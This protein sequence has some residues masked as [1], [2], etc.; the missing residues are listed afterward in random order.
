[1]ITLLEDTSPKYKRAPWISLIGLLTVARL[2]GA[3]PDDAGTDRGPDTTLRLVRDAGGFRGL[4][5][6]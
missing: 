6:C 3:S 2:L 1:M 4:T 5:P